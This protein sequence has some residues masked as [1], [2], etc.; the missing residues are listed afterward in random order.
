[1]VDAKLEKL[2]E[3]VTEMNK[4]GIPLSKIRDNLKQLGLKDPQVDAILA[5]ANIQPTTAELHQAVTSIDEKISSGE[6]VK[7]LHTE[8]KKN[9]DETT[10]TRADIEKLNDEMQEHRQKLDEIHKLVL[11]IAE[12]KSELGAPESVEEKVDLVLKKVEEFGPLLKSIESLNNKM[13][14]LNKKVLLKK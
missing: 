8:L 12:K 5:R 3:T 2:I 1:M 14:E 10:K 6:H 9:T 11:G 7:E 4:K 13:L